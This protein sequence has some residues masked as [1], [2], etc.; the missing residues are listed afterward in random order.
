MEEKKSRENAVRLKR[1]EEEWSMSFVHYSKLYVMKSKENVTVAFQN[2][3]VLSSSA[4][5][6]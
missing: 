3:Y 1:L 2:L 4:I 6:S 5:D